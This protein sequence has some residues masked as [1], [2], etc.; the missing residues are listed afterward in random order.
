M[1][2]DIADALQKNDITLTSFENKNDILMHADLQKEVGFK[3][4]ADGTYLVSM[5]CPMPDITAEMID[6]WFWW[7]PQDS[8]RY[9]VWFP[10]EHFS[11]SYAKKDRDFFLQPTL[12][13]F[14][15][16]TQYPVERIGG[17]RMPLR[18]DF[19]SPEAFGFSKQ[20]IEE[21]HIAK[22]VCGHVSA[23]GGLIRH[24][25]MAHIWKQ[26]ENGLFMFSRFWL[27]KTMNPLL[28][29]LIITDGMAKGMAQHCCI[30]YRNLAQI[31]APLYAD[32]R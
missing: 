10:G 8:L 5:V 28:R 4:A 3:K 25:E 13:P 30:E 31:L 22:I 27:G 7:H 2:S 9:Q 21:N 12:P 11:V 32:N 29:R 19:V 20:A 23:F 14:Q 18:I 16:N 15:A 6:W 26:T 1:P 17:F 24:T